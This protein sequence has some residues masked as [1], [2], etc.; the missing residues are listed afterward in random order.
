VRP[1]WSFP[2][3]LADGAGEPIFL[4]IARAIIDDVRR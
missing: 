2:I 3:A 4:R 1:G